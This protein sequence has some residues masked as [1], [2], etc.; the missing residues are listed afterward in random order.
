MKAMKYL[1]PMV[2]CVL[3]WPLASRAAAPAFQLS[4]LQKIISLRSPQISPDGKRIAVIVST[5]D[6]KTDKA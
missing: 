6:W 2:L 4:D 1:M 5:P 3:I